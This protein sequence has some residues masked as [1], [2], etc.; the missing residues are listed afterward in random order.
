LTV[1]KAYSTVPGQYGGALGPVP[2]V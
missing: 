1:P 2:G